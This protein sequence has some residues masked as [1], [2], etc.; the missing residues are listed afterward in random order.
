M[1]KTN[2]GFRPRGLTAVITLILVNAAGTVAQT[3]IDAT[4]QIK[5]LFPSTTGLV[6]SD[7]NM[8]VTASL[9]DIVAQINPSGTGTPSS[10]T[11]AGL[12]F[13]NAT[14]K[15]PNN[16]YECNG[17]SYVPLS[18]QK[19]NVKGWGCKGDGTTDD[20]A[21]LSS[22]FAFLNSTGN[23]IAYFP[24]GRYLMN[25]T[26]EVTSGMRL[27]GDS[28]Q[29]TFLIE[30][31]ATSDLMVLHDDTT[32][33]I[34]GVAWHFGQLITDISFAGKGTA[35]T[36]NL[37]VDETSGRIALD[38]VGFFGTGGS[39]ILQAGERAFYHDIHWSHV[40]RP[41]VTAASWSVNETYLDD[42]TIM[43]PGTTADDMFGTTGL[44][45]Y[46]VNA[47]NGVM[48]SSGALVQD[49]HAAIEL[50]G[51]IVNFHISHGSIK[52]LYIAG[53]KLRDAQNFEASHIYF[54]GEWPTNHN[55]DFIYGGS[56]EKA[57]LSSAITTGQTILDVADSKWWQSVVGTA[58]DIPKP[59][60]PG[61]DVHVVIR[62]P[63]FVAGSTTPSSLGNSITQGMY[64]YM[65]F[66]G[67]VH[68]GNGS[69]W[70]M[71]V[72]QR[73][74][75]SSTA[76]AWPAGSI[77]EETWG[78]QVNNNG[79][80]L[81]AADP[82]HLDDNHFNAVY[83]INNSGYS[84]TCDPNNEKTCGEIILGFEPDSYYRWGSPNEIR[85]IQ[86]WIHFSGNDRMVNQQDSVS[87]VIDTYGWAAVSANT[88]FTSNVATMTN[89]NQIP[90]GIMG[91]TYIRRNIFANG[92]GGEVDYVEPAANLAIYG[93]QPLVNGYVQNYN[94]STGL[95]FMHWTGS[96][97][98]NTFTMLNNGGIQL[99]PSGDPG[100]TSTSDVGKLWLNSTT[101]AFQVCKS[102][103]GT[104]GWSS[105]ATNP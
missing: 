46:N 69:G 15:A 51:N 97:F 92:D 94:A 78:D 13:T 48:P 99:A 32:S 5:N 28:Y 82:V 104:V 86:R 3:R 93:G 29:T 35:T 27:I 4:S 72:N 67:I 102:L 75:N 105:V 19:Y 43:D 36:G 31:N 11:V 21:C 85:H 71:Y 101:S 56:H 90:L 87:G 24:A 9:S 54:E 64:E 6:K 33:V 77:V 40:R 42:F 50:N 18:G 45:S 52:A 16:L 41:Y 57:T 98:T 30:T 89:A 61:V 58:A 1:I 95:G 80:E 39:G 20:T 96:A 68:D 76:R 26:L 81:L 2:R 79:S 53:I 60:G 91:G 65:T 55:P 62:P 70:H 66:K 88:T 37:L 49:Q 103:S 38:R 22:F 44:Y 23:A 17:S 8:F 73:A 10:C 63:D 47:T 25:G 14:E 84:V 7:G 100:C 59:T 83:P 74:T 34:A 12:F